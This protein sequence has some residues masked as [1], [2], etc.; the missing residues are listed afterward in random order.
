MGLGG[1]VCSTTGGIKM[2]RIGV[3]FKSLYNDVKRVMLPEAGIFIEKY[4]HIKEVIL[5]DR[6]VRSAMLILLCYLGLYA[7]GAIVGMLLGYPALEAFFES[8]SSAANVGL[9][10]GITNPAMPA[11]LKLTYI[12]QMWIGRLEFISVFTLFGFFTA[13]VRGK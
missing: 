6:Q 13:F 9:S 3:V 1:A 11:L 4:H 8:T 12:L 2:L 5:Q 10:C 7:S